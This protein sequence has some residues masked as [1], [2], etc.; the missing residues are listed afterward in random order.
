ML[1]LE[2]DTMLVL[3]PTVLLRSLPE[4]N[5]YFAFDVASG[6]QYRLNHTS[7]WILEAIGC[8]TSW[9][10]LRTRFLE[11]FAVGVQEGT[12]DLA[13]IVAQFHEEKIIR[14]LDCGKQGDR[15]SLRAAHSRQGEGDD[16]STADH[17]RR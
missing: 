13:A 10:A 8:G 15:A 3:S 12:S 6:D 1:A 17:R 9:A 4:Q 14:R 2:A 7:F 16:L 5:W 11:R